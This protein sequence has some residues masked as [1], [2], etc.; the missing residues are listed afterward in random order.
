MGT[1]REPVQPAAELV[2]PVLSK[3][4][5]PFGHL[6]NRQVPLGVGE[7]HGDPSGTC[8]TAKLPLALLQDMGT[9]REPVQPPS[10]FLCC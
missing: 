9:L 2:L 7:G 3:T 10:C 8:A 4:V 6:C 5:G 1:L